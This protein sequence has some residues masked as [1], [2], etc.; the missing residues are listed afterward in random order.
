MPS[1]IPNLV[2]SEQVGCARIAKHPA[3]VGW[4]IAGADVPL[5]EV[6]GVRRSV[7]PSFHDGRTLEIGVDKMLTPFRETVKI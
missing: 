5:F 2:K 6:S 1:D 3:A 4:R 7:S